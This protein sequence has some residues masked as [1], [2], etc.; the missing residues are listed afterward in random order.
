MYL[1]LPNSHHFEWGL[2]ALK[3][4]KHVLLEKP[5]TSNAIEAKK[6]FDH[7]LVTACDAPVLLEAFHYRFHPA[8]Q[9]FL[10]LIHNDPSA[11]PIKN[12]YSQSFMPKGNFPDNDIRFKY[13]LAGG[14]LMDFAAYN[15]SHV[16]QMLDDPHPRV[17]SVVFRTHE[18]SSATSPLEG[19]NPEQVDEAVSASYISQTG[20]I[21]H[22]VADM[23]S[24]GG[25]PLL[26]RSWTQNWPSIG[27]PKCTAEL[28]EK[29]IDDHTTH[30]EKHLVQRVVTLYNHIFPHVYHCITIED[31]HIIRLGSEDLR[32]W[33]E[34]KKV[35][36][37]TWPGDSEDCHGMDWWTTY[38][39]QLEEFVNHIKARQGN[40]LWISREDSISQMEVIDETYR[41]G[42]L[43]LRPTSTFDI[44][45]GLKE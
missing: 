42:D 20:A 7:P 6:L 1:A 29:L 33:V 13:S 44:D 38:R 5:S 19:E 25:W 30:G 9:T 12:A 26:P 34:R 35:K 36:A 14:C 40:G 39:Y 18:H 15:I 4:G 22:V 45:D 23:S 43:K 3:A 17:Q 11:G 27:W 8:W 21:G 10:D 16:R 32:S 31:K 41:K 2:R 24:R 28:E 37:Y